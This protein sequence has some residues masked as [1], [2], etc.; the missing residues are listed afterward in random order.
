MISRLILKFTEYKAT[1]NTNPLSISLA[2]L[3]C[4]IIGVFLGWIYSVTVYIPIIYFNILITVGFGL[5]LV[6]SIQIVS[7]VF[8]IRDKKSRIL[9]VVISV[10]IA[11]Y[12]HWI[13]FIVQVYTSE[14]PSFINYINYWIHPRGI[15]E[16]ISEINKLGTWGFGF[17]NTL[18]IRGIVLSIIWLV[19]AII[20]FFIAI[21]RIFQFP[22]NPFSEKLNKWYPKIALKKEFENIYSSKRFI[23]QIEEKGIDH[24]LNLEDGL[25]F[26]YS[27]ISIFYL[28][29]E[30]KQYLSIDSVS[31][32]T[33]NESKATI[34]V[35]VKPFEVSTQNAKKLI[36]KF[37]TE[38]EFFL[39]Y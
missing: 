5:G 12:S 11:Y 15:F 25:A 20:I 7:K 32:D 34:N 13:S 8:K 19:E 23:S 9:I 28:E 21:G 3:I 27:K 18:F 26:K 22:E 31:I 38:K 14:F 10:L 35:M 30:D 2:I 33:K 6:Y 39:D 17:S 37:D 29:G 36:K 4:S 1:K 16:N 24:V